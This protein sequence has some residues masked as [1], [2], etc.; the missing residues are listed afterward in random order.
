MGYTH[1]WDWGKPKER[2]PE[3]KKAYNLAKKDII[4]IIKANMN[5]LANGIGEHKSK[6]Y[7][8]DEIIFNGIGDNAHESFFIPDSLKK[9]MRSDF[10]KTAQK[11]YDI[12]VVACL[13]VLKD[14]LQDIINISGQRDKWHKG[15]QMAS[16][17]LKREIKNPIIDT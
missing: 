17:A 5:I 16:E 8:A 4:K 2:S 3:S 9:Y 7:I 13:A 12:V 1:H 14:H 10:C 15:V 6:P 11:E